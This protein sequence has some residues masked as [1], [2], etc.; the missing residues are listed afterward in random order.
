MEDFNLITVDTLNK[1]FD[2]LSKAGYVKNKEVNKVIILT[3]LSRLLNDFYEYITEE[4]YNDIIKSEEGQRQNG[5]W[6]CGYAVN[7]AVKVRN[8]ADCSDFDFLNYPSYKDGECWNNG[9]TMKL[10]KTRR[11]YRKDA[12]WF[13]ETFVAMTNA[14]KKGEIIYE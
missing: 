3:F 2:I 10:N 11:E 4:D 13:L 14:H 6:T 1:Y 5:N 12:R 9:I 8:D 7:A